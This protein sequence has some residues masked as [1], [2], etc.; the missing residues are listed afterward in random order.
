MIGAAHYD[1]FGKGKNLDWHSL[2]DAFD[3]IP[4]IMVYSE[5]ATKIISAQFNGVIKPTTAILD[6]SKIVSELRRI[7]HPSF[8]QRLLEFKPIFMDQRI[9]FERQMALWKFYARNGNEEIM[10][11]YLDNHLN[12]VVAMYDMAWKLIQL[13][14]DVLK[15]NA[16]RQSQTYILPN[17]PIQKTATIA[18]IQ[19]ASRKFQM[20]R[21]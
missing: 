3:L 20:Q 12:N 19:R 18:E 16:D 2:H 8:K 15:F 13:G 4:L 6:L 7:S 5:N 14:K 11:N 17:K 21:K 10:Q 9:K 1:F